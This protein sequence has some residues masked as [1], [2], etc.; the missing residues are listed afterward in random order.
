MGK[1]PDPTVQHCGWTRSRMQVGQSDQVGRVKVV[2]TEVRARSIV[3]V[4]EI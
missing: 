1:E 2:N 4:G 3:W